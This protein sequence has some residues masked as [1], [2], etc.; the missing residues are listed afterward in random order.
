[1]TRAES[2]GGSDRQSREIL[3]TTQTHTQKRNWR[4]GLNVSWMDGVGDRAP[5]AGAA[6]R[7]RLRRRRLV[8]GR[9]QLIKR[10][11]VHHAFPFSWRL[12]L[13]S[14]NFTL[15]GRSVLG[16]RDTFCITAHIDSFAAR[17]PHRELIG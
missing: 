7:T 1:M 16:A 15:T 5:Q 4:E 6:G 12:S 10:T 3:H 2:N 14:T 8:H 11:S 13:F 9:R 17:Y